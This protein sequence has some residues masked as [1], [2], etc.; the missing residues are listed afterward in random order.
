MS[1]L[2]RALAA[3]ILLFLPGAAGRAQVA[4][5]AVGASPV[6]LMADGS[7]EQRVGRLVFRGG[8][9]LDASHQRF[10]GWSDLWV[11]QDGSR[12]IAI[13][14]RG[15]WM[16]LRLVHDAQGRLTGVGP[17][18]IGPLGDPRGLQLHGNPS[19][20]EGLAA[21]PDGGFLVSFERRHRI[22]HYPA[23][24][25]PFGRPPRLLP[26]P[27][28]IAAAPDNG[29]LEALARL[30]DGRLVAIAEAL[31]E[32]GAHAAWVF[33]DE[34]W[35]RFSY[36]AEPGFSPAG[37]A[38]LPGGDLIV[39]ERAFAFLAGFRVRLTRVP[40]A[41]LGP[42]VAARGA[43]L[44]RLDARHTVDNF[45]GVATRAGANG[46]TLLY[47]IADDNFVRW[48]RTLL[49]MFAIAD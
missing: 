1:W 10:G 37:A 38:G 13:S 28:G 46:E 22:W 29:A 14:D 9:A 36:R 39:L 25:V 20:A 16:E 12:L 15:S 18:R 23:A 47:L 6:P 49:M 34:R 35:G 42:G 45:E 8:L 33:A 41:Q 4:P 26:T 17:A 43:E 40:Q 11:A 27:P 31:V 30:A 44:A 19:D 32:N 7:A 2:S 24:P 3:L 21:L 5:I 48:Q